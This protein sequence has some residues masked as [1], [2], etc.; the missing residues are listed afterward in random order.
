VFLL[1]TGLGN[2]ETQRKVK[3]LL[4]VATSTVLD[5]SGLCKNGFCIDYFVANENFLIFCDLLFFHR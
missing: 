4:H 5:G 1:N 3:E 2:E